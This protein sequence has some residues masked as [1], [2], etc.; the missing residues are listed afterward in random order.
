MTDFSALASRTAGA[1]LLPDDEGFAEAVAG[2]NLAVQNRPDA[3]LTP[4]SADDVVEAVRFARAAKVSIRVQ[5]TGH[6]SESPITDGLLLSLRAL[7]RVTV[8]PVARTA[9][10]GGGVRW[11][12][13]VAAAGEHGLAP[14]TGASDT[15]GAVGFLLGGGLSPLA[16]AF[17]VGSDR[18]RSL[19]VVTGEGELVTAS[20]DEHPELFWA[21]RGGKG[22]LGV[23]IEATVELLE[24]PT[25]YGGALFFDIAD[26]PEVIAGW[27]DWTTTAESASTTSVSVL[28]FPDLEQVPPPFRGRQLVSLRFARP[29]SAAEAEPIAAPLR[30]LAP[31]YL[32]DLVER[33][34]AQIAR[35]HSDPAGPLPG[36][37]RGAML[38]RPDA[39]FATA[40][41][42]VAASP[43]APFLGVEVRHIGSATE[44]DVP[45]GSAVGGRENDYTLTVIGVPNPDLF[46]SV[47][48]AAYA[49][50][51]AA[52]DP[53]IAPT[54]T[55]N[56][57]IDT[58][59]PSRFASAWPAPIFE[60]LARVR[61]E[62]DPDGVFPYAP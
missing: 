4:A 34:A 62:H 16:R 17:G 9:T 10:F 19:R 29:G 39:D 11:G 42:G 46:A 14:V 51:R 53:W 28:R 37:T 61:A 13:V 24:L 49:G 3:V 26:A 60:R 43:S 30:A 32:D 38:R 25:F 58:S 36:W 15:V 27:L 52:I 48:P 20:A 40:L 21:L 12:A 8:D 47:L 31:I 41:L 33:P 44:V 5:A 22:G 1:L 18:L 59:D 45:E 6:G 7:D 35:V 54:T 2:F 55:I 23:V 56:W 50:L 57:L